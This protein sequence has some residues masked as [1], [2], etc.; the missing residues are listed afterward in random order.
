[1]AWYSIVAW[2]S[3]LLRFLSLGSSWLRFLSLG[4]E[5]KLLYPLTK[6]ASSCLSDI[7]LY[8]TIYS[9]VVIHENMIYIL[10]I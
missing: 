5:F 7:K 6:C 8:H 3:K 4:H 2:A 10:I 9:L 1:M